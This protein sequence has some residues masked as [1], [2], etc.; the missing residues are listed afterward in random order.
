MKGY[1]KLV[2]VLIIVMAFA[3]V[4]SAGNPVIGSWGND[5][6]NNQSSSITVN[7]SDSIKFN[8]TANQTINI[9]WH[10]FK[11]SA[12]NPSTNNFFETSWDV[13]GT[14]DVTVYAT[15]ASNQSN[16]V[17][18]T[19][20][21]NDV[22]PPPQVTGLTNDTPT[23]S[24]VNL[25]WTAN[26]ASDL[27]GYRVYRDG[28]QVGG[29]IPKTQNYYN[30][31]SLAAGTYVFNVSAYDDNGLVGESSGDVSVTMASGSSTTL[32]ISDITNTT[33]TSNSVTIKW[34][35][36]EVGDSLVK[37]GTDSSTYLT[38]QHENSS[39]YEISHSITLAEL[40]SDTTY[41]YA[42]NST[43]TSSGNTDESARRKFKTQSS[44]Y[45]TG[46]RIWDA[47]ED[48]D[49]NYTWDARSFTGFYYDLDDDTSTET[50]TIHLDSYTDRTIEEDD[51]KYI[52]TAADIDFEYD[53]WGT[54]KVIGFM[55]EKY[56]AGYEEDNTS[57]A[58]EDISLISKDMLSKVLIDEDEKHT[59]STGASLELKE[60]YELKVIQLDIDGGQAQIELMKNGKS[61]DTDVVTSPDDYIYEKDLGK[62]DDV[63]LVAV[64]ITSVFAGTESNMLVIEGI[65]Q[66]SDDTISVDTGDEYDDMEVKSSSGYTIEMR[67][68]EDIDLE[69]DEIVDI[70]GSLKFL[71]A[72]SNTLRFALYEEITEPG[73][74]DIRGTVYDT[75]GD[76]TW[77]NMNFEG[78]Y[79]DIDDDLGTEELRV[80][81]SGNTI[82]EG[83]L[84][85]TTTPDLVRFELSE[86]GSYEVIGFMAEPYFAGYDE[87]KTDDE[88]TNDDFSLISKDMLSKVLID[89]E[90]DRS[91]STGA[92]L[93][94]EEGYE[95]KIIQLDADGGQ[96]QLELIKDGKSIDTDIVKS[97][98]TYVY[99]KDL[100]KL[101]DVPIIAIRI[102]NV[103]AGTETAMVT[104]EGA[105]QI[106]DDPISIDTGD[107]YGEMEITTATSSGIT[108]KNKESDIDLEGDE[109]IMITDTIGFKVSEDEDRYYLFVRRTVGSL[110][111]LAI[112]I[113]ETPI[114]DEELVITVTAT[115]DGDPV[116]GA[117]VAV[118]GENLGLTDSNGEVRHTPGDAGTFTVTASKE[119]YDS[120]SED[121]DILTED[122]A[123]KDALDLAM[124][125]VVDPDEEMIIRVTSDGDAI[126]GAM[127]TW[128]D[129]EIGETDDTGSLTYSHEET[130]TYTVTASKS[131]Y[132]DASEKITVSI[133]AAK[134]EL[135]GISLPAEV[136]T[137]KSFTTTTNVTN[138][139]DIEGTYRAELVIDDG[140]GTII[141]AG[142]QNV[143]LAVGDTETVQFTYKLAE[144]G[145]YTVRIG[146]KSGEITVTASESK[147]VLVAVILLLLAV[148]GGVGYVLISSAPDGGW[149]A[150]KL[151]EAIKEKIPGKKGL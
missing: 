35:T 1:I 39:T 70:M 36:N 119:N 26:G 15:N 55:A 151:I 67:N 150:E 138:V 16:T 18:W 140:N 127:I 27:A 149:T 86:W 124:P 9:T 62:L 38:D 134:F 76:Q 93:Q 142:S 102:G 45:S 103:F 95:L 49:L 24:T 83:D 71:V 146:D 80:E 42:V 44:G 92:S 46:Y 51:L 69:E 105:F 88:I 72:D 136:A 137:G 96:A 130:G 65:F 139:G 3:S 64:R 141:D 99:T 135:D 129:E 17:P 89:V 2:S 111:A 37:Y 58:D 81:N 5:V 11:G 66:V 14:Y 68:I 19:I 23:T 117:D 90:D 21:V 108:M 82:A 147:T 133:P 50:L 118:G 126:E 115:S 84:I 97:P 25:T 85:Y 41:Y 100:G 43:N 4:A 87:E 30:A 123:E 94:L 74:H 109:T 10:W 48:M 22:T 75:T 131:R 120:A 12:D 33:P 6:T 53:D 143:T 125:D 121:V 20:T 98:D 91:I 144:A 78:F 122:E 63:P 57:I 77:D 79:Y 104:I 31:T 34:D 101:D 28:S 40:S 29:D 7:E 8:A 32:A 54:Y 106:S 61:V 148:L 56:F 128:D 113:S 114:V 47:D 73:T 110:D 60:G 13:D 107:E 112:D 116:E 52:T 59:V 132:I 145:A